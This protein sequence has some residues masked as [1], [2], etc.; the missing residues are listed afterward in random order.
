LGNQTLFELRVLLELCPKGA[1]A[2]LR[3]HGDEPIG[4]AA[5]RKPDCDGSIARIGCTVFQA[6]QTALRFDV[7]YASPAELLSILK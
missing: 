7:N 4:G 5:V 1:R 2:L 3:E 6:D